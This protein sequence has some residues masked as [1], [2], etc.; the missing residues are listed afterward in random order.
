[1]IINDF[2]NMVNGDHIIIVVIIKYIQS[3]N[4]KVFLQRI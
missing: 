1:M 3:F 2:I 4:C